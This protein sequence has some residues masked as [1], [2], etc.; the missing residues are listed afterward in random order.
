MCR[1]AGAMRAATSTAS[2]RPAS[3]RGEIGSRRP[4][5]GIRVSSMVRKSSSPRSAVAARLGPIATAERRRGVRVGRQ[6]GPPRLRVPAVSVQRDGQM[7]LTGHASHFSKAIGK[8]GPSD[9]SGPATGCNRW[10][11]TAPRPRAGDC[12]SSGRSAGSRVRRSRLPVR[13]TAPSA[14]PRRRCALSVQILLS[15]A[16]SASNRRNP[17]PV[18]GTAVQQPDQHAAVGRREFVGRVVLQPRQHRR[19]CACRSAVA[20]STASSAS[21]GCANASSNAAGTNLS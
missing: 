17:P 14:Y 18:T 3:R 9:G 4:G 2:P 11:D 15:S 13:P 16:V 12:R 19:H 1:V 8:T 5:C 20:Y 21:S 6:G 7:Q 10:P